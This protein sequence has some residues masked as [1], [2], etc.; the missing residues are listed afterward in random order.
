MHPVRSIIVVGGGTAGWLAANYLWKALNGDP[1]LPVSITLIESQ[2]IGII[3]VGEATVPT[4]RQTLQTLDIPEHRLFGE[5]DATLKNGIRFEGWR[6]GGDPQTD[7]YYHPFEPPPVMEGFSTMVHWLNL[8]QRGLSQIAFT[9]AAVVQPALCDRGLSPKLMSSDAFDAPVP[10]AYHL[11]AVKLAG[12]LKRSGVERGVHHVLGTVTHAQVTEAGIQSVSL[13]DGRTFSADF[14]VD[15]SGFRALLIGDALSEPWISYS[16]QL[17]CD[18]AVACPFSYAIDKPE[19]RSHT[20]SAA[21]DAGWIW[22]IDLQSRRGSG[23][24]YSSAFCTE[25]IAEATLREHNKD[26]QASALPRHLKMR[27]GRRQNV[28]VKN[29]LAVGLSS[30]FI[31]PLESTAIYMVEHSLG[32]FVD[33][34]RNAPGSR[35]AQAKFNTLLGELYDEIKDFVV[36]HYILSSRRDTAFWREYT[37]NVR[38]S[39]ALA[40]LLAL[41]DEKLPG[42]TDINQRLSLFGPGNYFYILS[43]MHALPS[44]GIA[45]ANHI[46]P[47]TSQRVM[48]QIARIR[49]AA[50][51]Q[52][53]SMSDYVQKMRAASTGIF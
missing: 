14:F 33:Y 31:E 41:W 46:A 45:Q 32:L 8:K 21:K 3:G 53:P 40:D 27:V 26:L 6:T 9:D 20:T 25:E 19:L 22:E 39:S 34:L 13:D 43:G 51:A 35:M 18:R 49:E 37:E 1:E 5:A 23:Y 50:V 12:L 38:I 36:L 47:A 16:D 7:Y 29:C 11:D 24:V 42:P 48:D 30:G 28:W 10:Y 4:M 15:C 17:L 52:S 44:R 2:E